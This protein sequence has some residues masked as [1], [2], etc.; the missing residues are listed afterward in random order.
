MNDVLFSPVVKWPLIAAG[1]V[2]IF[3]AIAWTLWLGLKS[4]ARASLLGG[5]RLLALAGLVLMLIQPQKRY[6]E[7]TILKPQ[8]A[9]VVDSSESMS[10]AVDDAQP[11][12]ADRVKEWL[13]SPAV[14]KAR[15]SFDV[16]VFSFDAKLGDLPADA[17]ELAFKGGVSNLVGAM[18]EVQQR[19][20]GQPL[21]AITLLSD[22]LDTTGVAK[23]ATF[24]SAAPVF[25]FELEKPFAPKAKERRVSLGTLDFPARV[26]VGWDSEIKADIAGSGMSGQ[27]IRVELWRDGKKEREATVA[28]NEDEQTRPVAFPLAP[29]APGVLQFEL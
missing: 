26:V 10:D 13:A 9:V 20:T 5:F 25:T 18:S 23:A 17:K 8:L 19:F 14:A 29:A 28:F 1:A 21:A 6:D 2:A 4:R 27:T 11:R 3:A 22:G 15:E 7:V 12:R 24:S 16:R